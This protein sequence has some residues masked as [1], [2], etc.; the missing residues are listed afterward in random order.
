MKLRVAQ[1]W[2]RKIDSRLRVAQESLQVLVAQPALATSISLPI[3]A[4]KHLTSEA[5]PMQERASYPLFLNSQFRL[6]SVLSSF[7]FLPCPY[8]RPPPVCRLSSKSPFP[9][10]G[11]YRQSGPANQPSSTPVF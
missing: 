11:F 6:T 10:T 5:P 2:F 8:L 1:P 9:S 4:L 7:L 3:W